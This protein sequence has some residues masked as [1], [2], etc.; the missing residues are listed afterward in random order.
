MISFEVRLM[1]VILYGREG[2]RGSSKAGR[3]SVKKLRGVSGP[4]RA[5]RRGSTVTSAPRTV[6]SL[7]AADGALNLFG[8]TSLAE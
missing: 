5:G 7:R 6:T 4:L 8:L 2:A 3:V 1:L